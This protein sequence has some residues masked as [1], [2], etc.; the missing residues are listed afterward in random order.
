V[1][2]RGAAGAAAG[3]ERRRHAQC[4]HRAV[5]GAQRLHVALGRGA[6]VL[7]RRAEPLWPGGERQ[8]PAAH[9]RADGRRG[10]RPRLLRLPL[11]HGVH[12]AA[13]GLHRLRLGVGH[14][15]GAP[16]NLPDRCDHPAARPLWLAAQAGTARPR[17]VMDAGQLLRGA[18]AAAGPARPAGLRAACAGAVGFRPAT[19]CAGRGCA[20]PLDAQATDGLLADPVSAAGGAEPAALAIPGSIRRCQCGARGTI[21][22]AR[23]DLVGR[24]A[25]ADR[26]IP[27]LHRAGRAG[28]DRGAPLPGAWHGG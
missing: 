18:R 20:G 21:V 1:G 6:L 9:L 16:R 7:A 12:P 19:R 11:L 4:A 22:R 25:G 10:R 5:S 3:R 26:A 2:Y 27:V 14:L 17:A 15:D 28:V 8:H 24:L 23:A 13:A